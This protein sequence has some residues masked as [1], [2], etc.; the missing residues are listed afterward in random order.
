MHTLITVYKHQV[1]IDWSRDSLSALWQN[2][3]QF[4]V[5]AQVLKCACVCASAQE[6]IGFSYILFGYKPQGVATATATAM[7]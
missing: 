6:S 1:N 5:C 7:Q 2:T 4:A 3:T